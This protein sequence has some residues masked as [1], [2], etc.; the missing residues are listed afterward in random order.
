[1]LWPKHPGVRPRLYVA[2]LRH[3]DGGDEPQRRIRLEEGGGY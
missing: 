3:G 2:V 1:L